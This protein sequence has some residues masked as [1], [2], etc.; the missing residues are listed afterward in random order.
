MPNVLGPM[1]RGPS[2]P[3]QDKVRGMHDKLATMKMEEYWMQT[4]KVNVGC[5]DEEKTIPKVNFS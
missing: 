2:K 4:N 1:G 5:Y 3:F